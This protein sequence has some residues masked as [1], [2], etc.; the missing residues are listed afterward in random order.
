MTTF[1]IFSKRVEQHIEGIREGSNRTRNIFLFI[2]VTAL[3]IFVALFNATLT[4]QRHVNHNE[5][6]YLYYESIVKLDSVRESNQELRKHYADIYFDRQF[7]TIPLLGMRISESDLNIF[8]PIA[9]LIFTTWYFYGLRRENHTI[10]SV[11]NDFDKM[12]EK[13]RNNSFSQNES[14]DDWK[15]L[16]HNLYSG[17]IQS[18]VLSVPTAKDYKRKQSEE[19]NKNNIARPI[20]NILNWVPVVILALIFIDDVCEFPFTEYLQAE[21]IELTLLNVFLLVLMGIVF[22]Q[23]RI[24]FNIIND[25][26]KT[27]NEMSDTV[28]QADMAYTL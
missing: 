22:Y 28:K 12:V 27:L 25:T 16:L 7:F 23:T 13:I 1:K 11:K 26:R 21:W 9:M 14:A 2:N 17:C 15:V 8:A 10:I 24:I 19:F 5:R 18:F 4:W 6:G 3:V 20:M